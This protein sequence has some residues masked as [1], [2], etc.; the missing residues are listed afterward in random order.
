MTKESAQATVQ[1]I[2]RLACQKELEFKLILGRNREQ[3]KEIW[4]PKD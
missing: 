4:F 1:M 3:V 2:Q